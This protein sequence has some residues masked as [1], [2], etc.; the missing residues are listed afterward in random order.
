[1]RFAHLS[2]A[3]AHGAAPTALAIECLGCGEQRALSYTPA[4]RVDGGD[5]ARCGYAGWVRAGELDAA[6][7][8]ELA[9][10]AFALRA[11]QLPAHSVI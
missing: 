10:T 1:M 5:C 8:Q 3:T 4:G 11:S 7:R 2:A 9:A 6:A